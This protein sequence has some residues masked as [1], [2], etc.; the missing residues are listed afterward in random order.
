MFNERV[1]QHP[2]RIQN[3]YL[4]YTLLL[5]AVSKIK[6]QMPLVQL[7][8]QPEDDIR[9][10]AL[11]SSLFKALPKY[12]KGFDSMFF[13]I[14]PAYADHLKTTFRNMANLMDCVACERCRLW[15]KVQIYGVGTALKALTANNLK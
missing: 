2:D 9:A 14:R 5:R 1:G 12:P 13:A 10:K 3:M 7:G 15:G 6:S 4:T 8:V 11:L